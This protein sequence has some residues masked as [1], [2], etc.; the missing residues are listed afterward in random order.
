MTAGWEEGV[1][2]CAGGVDNVSWNRRTVASP[3][4]AAGGDYDPTALAAA[5]ISP[6]EYT[7]SS[8]AFLALVNQWHQG[9]TP[10]YGVIGGSP[11]IGTSD[12]VFASRGHINS[13]LRP[14]LVVT[15]V[16]P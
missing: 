10:N 4:L 15:Y 3:W 14:K 12:T 9:V 6:F 2:S 8:V 7:W 16:L 11:N 5:A 13:D 1:R